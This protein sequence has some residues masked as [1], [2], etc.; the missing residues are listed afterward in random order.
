MTDNV[1]P[2]KL[3]IKN[4]F[5]QKMLYLYLLKCHIVPHV[6]YIYSIECEMNVIL[7]RIPVYVV[8]KIAYFQCRLRRQLPM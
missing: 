3:I 7:E 5:T 4:D 2:N 8:F 1:H 6:V